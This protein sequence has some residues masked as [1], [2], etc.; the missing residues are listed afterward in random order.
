MRQEAKA[1]REAMVETRRH[2]VACHHYVRFLPT[3][4][5]NLMQVI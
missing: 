3:L 4:T 2:G 1:S 5:C